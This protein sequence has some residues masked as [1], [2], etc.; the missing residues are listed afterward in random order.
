[1]QAA[2]GVRET[3][4]GRWLGAH[5]GASPPSNAS[6]LSSGEE[7]AGIAEPRNVFQMGIRTFL[8]AFVSPFLLRDNLQTIA[9]IPPHRGI[10]GWM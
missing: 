3:V 9:R 8:V 6:L 4:A 7:C 2:L 1:M 5:E 10:F